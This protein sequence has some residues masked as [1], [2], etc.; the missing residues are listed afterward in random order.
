MRV[1]IR[2][3]INTSL[4]RDKVNALEPEK[5]QEELERARKY[6]EEAAKLLDPT[7][8]PWLFGQTKPTELDAHLIVVIARLQDVER[9][10]LIPETLKAYGRKAMSEPSWQAI[11]QSRTTM[12]D[13]SGGKEDQ[14]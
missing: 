9:D 4:R 14:H 13:G 7:S 10:F 1:R 3:D 8:G 6:L 12:Y 2:A 5:V 11:M